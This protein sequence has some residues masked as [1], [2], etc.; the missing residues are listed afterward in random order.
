M[1]IRWITACL[2]GA[3]TI[4][5]AIT[6]GCDETPLLAPSDGAM[7]VLLRD[8]ALSAGDFER[9]WRTR[10]GEQERAAIVRSV[11]AADP[12]AR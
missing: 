2:V 12:D 9:A 6:V 10:L 8:A 7:T 11:L 1:S 5:A 3:M 4:I